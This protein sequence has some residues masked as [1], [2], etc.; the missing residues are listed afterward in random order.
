MIEDTDDCQCLQPTTMAAGGILTPK[1]TLATPKMYF[2]GFGRQDISD[3]RKL[4]YKL[5]G[6]R[7]EAMEEMIEKLVERMDKMES[8]QGKLM[9]LT[10]EVMALRNKLERVEEIKDKLQKENENLKKQL[11]REMDEVKES[12]VKVIRDVENKQKEWMKQ[13]EGK[14]ESLK[15][16]MKQQEKERDDIK[17]KVISVIKEKKKLVR[18]AVDKVK[19][20]L[21]RFGQNFAFFLYSAYGILT[22]WPIRRQRFQPKDA[23]FK[24]LAL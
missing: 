13:Q 8:Q 6:R 3:G 14:E 12:N 7:R 10:R 23:I 24:G 1:S 11:K 21:R 19:G 22:T 20:I 5:E 16:I 9:D 2:E 4:N 17:E 18:D 15:K